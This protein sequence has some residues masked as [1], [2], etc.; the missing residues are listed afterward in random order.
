M[1]SLDKRG[2]PRMSITQRLE[3]I[4]SFKPNW[5]G[6]GAVPMS[7]STLA[8]TNK[9]LAL[10]CPGAISKLHYEDIIPSPY[11]TITLQWSNG[12]SIVQIE[13]ADSTVAVLTDVEGCHNEDDIDF[14]N[15]L[16]QSFLNALNELYNQ[17]LCTV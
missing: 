15:T 3:A 1:E 17:S 6:W 7:Q 5:S 12:E 9:V 2:L 11:G 10:L 4:A 16:P 13:I 8:N 14:N